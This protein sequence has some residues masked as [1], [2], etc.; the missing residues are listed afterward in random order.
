MAKIL[1]AALLAASSATHG[2]PALR[3]CPEC[4]GAGIV[5]RRGRNGDPQDEES[6]DCPT[7]DPH[8]GR[9]SLGYVEARR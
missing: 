8:D 6:W 3:V 7:C 9:A 1:P 5:G 4:R 2:G